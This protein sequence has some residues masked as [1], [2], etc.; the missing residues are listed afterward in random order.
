[1]DPMVFYTDIL[2]YVFKCHSDVKVPPSM[3]W[4]T[5]EHPS[6]MV[7]VNADT[8][9]SKKT[10]EL[11]TVVMASIVT[12]MSMSTTS[13]CHHV[14]H[15]IRSGKRDFRLENTLGRKTLC[16]SGKVASVVAEVGWPRSAKVVDK[17]FTG[18]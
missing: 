12:I 14:N 16:F 5:N 15:I 17:K 9:L 6:K 4:K 3:P 11:R 1:M 10:T 7:S 13:S 2:F 18:L 8:V